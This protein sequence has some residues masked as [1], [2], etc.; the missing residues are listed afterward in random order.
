LPSPWAGK[1]G[2]HPASRTKAQVEAVL[3]APTSIEAAQRLG[4]SHQTLYSLLAHYQLPSPWGGPSLS[5][6][7]A[8]LKARLE[9]PQTDSVTQRYRAALTELV[10]EHPRLGQVLSWR[11]GLAQATPMTLEQVGTELRVTRERAR[12]LIAAASRLLHRNARRGGTPRGLTRRSDERGRRQHHPEGEPA[13]RHRRARGDHRTRA[14]TAAPAAATV[15]TV[16][17]PAARPHPRRLTRIVRITDEIRQR[18]RSQGI[19]REQLA[20]LEKRAFVPTA[21]ER[22]ILQDLLEG[23]G[24]RAI[25]KRARMSEHQLVRVLYVR[26]GREGLFAR[27]GAKNR[28]EAALLAVMM[29]WIERCVVQ[30][31]PRSPGARYPLAD[32]Q[33]ELL[34]DS[35][36]GASSVAPS[37][38]RRIRT[39]LGVAVPTRSSRAL[40]AVLGLGFPSKEDI[41][42]EGLRDEWSWEEIADQVRARAWPEVGSDQRAIKKW[43]SEHLYPALGAASQPEAVL[44]ALQ[45]RQVAIDRPYPPASVLLSGMSPFARQVFRALGLGWSYAQVAHALETDV[46]RVRNAVSGRDPDISGALRRQGVPAK[47][48]GTAAVKAAQIEETLLRPQEQTLLRAAVEADFPIEF[49][50]S[51]VAKGAGW[52]DL[53]RFQRTLRRSSHDQYSLLIHRHPGDRFSVETVFQPV[54]K[55]GLGTVRIPVGTFSIKTVREDGQAI[56]EVSVELPRPIAVIDQPLWRGEMARVHRDLGRIVENNARRNGRGIRV[57]PPTYAMPQEPLWWDT[58]ARGVRNVR[59]AVAAE[60]PDIWSDYEQLLKLAER[61]P[62]RE[63]LRQR[64][65]ERLSRITKEQFPHVV[66]QAFNRQRAPYFKGSVRVVLNEAFPEVFAPAPSRIGGGPGPTQDIRALP[67]EDAERLSAH[68]QHLRALEDER[69]GVHFYREP[70]DGEPTAGLPAAPKDGERRAAQAGRAAEGGQEKGTA[71]ERA[72]LLPGGDVGYTEAGLTSGS[73]SREGKIRLMWTTMTG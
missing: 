66:R 44:K 16:A 69:P 54:S 19:L 45:G 14:A 49:T 72:T 34:L 57:L 43:V 65:V 42:L 26:E 10:A 18:L 30:L 9:G 33:R 60:W 40:L 11:L 28:N 3:E 48:I 46:S 22:R 62:D 25:A 12:Q 31:L 20:E 73:R 6:Q 17:R 8:R 2:R 67:V 68:T 29:G 53:R 32:E 41:V 7:E 58:K 55:F 63:P 52:S 35:V 61:A 39:Q 56:D 27:V 70:E 59:W 36:A 64:L 13:E 4:V 21:F 1:H 24:L 5:R 23:R 38:L 15:Q 71:V 47:V 50:P 37:V 51:D